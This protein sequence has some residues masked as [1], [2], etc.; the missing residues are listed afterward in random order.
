MDLCSHCQQRKAKRSCPALGSPLCPL[1]CG[2]LR[3]KELHCPPGCPYLS[4]HKPYQENKVIQKKGTFSEEVLNDERLA[5]LTLNIE[6]SLKELGERRPT[7]SDKDAILAL[8]YA[9]NRVEKGRS[10]IVFSEDERPSKNEAAETVLLSLNQ[11]RFQ[12]K[13]ILPQNLESYTP[14]EKIKCLENTVLAVK[15]MARGRFDGRTYLQD[16]SRR[17]KGLQDTSNRDKILTRT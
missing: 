17:L 11:C 3:E 12:R 2:R 1:C 5:W 16:L 7:F 10:L 9:K 4:Q 14:E 6:A 8:E 15:H 13:I